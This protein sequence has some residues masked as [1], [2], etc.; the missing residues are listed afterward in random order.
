MFA[1]VD[2]KVKFRHCGILQNY[3]LQNS[4]TLLFTKKKV[5]LLFFFLK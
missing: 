2:E 4:P 3:P 5:M 1:L